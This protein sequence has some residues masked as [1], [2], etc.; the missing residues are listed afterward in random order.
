MNQLLDNKKHGSVGETLKQSA[1]AR[2]NPYE[3][4]VK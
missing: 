2:D 3:E 1:I 4:F